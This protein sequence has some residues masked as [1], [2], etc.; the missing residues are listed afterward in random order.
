MHAPNT[1]IHQCYGLSGTTGNSRASGR[2]P[3]RCSHRSTAGSPRALTRLTCKRPSRYSTNWGDNTG[4]QNTLLQQIA[5]F[6][7]YG[8]LTAFEKN[9]HAICP[10]I[11]APQDDISLRQTRIGWPCSL[12]SIAQSPSTISPRTR[13]FAADNPAV[14]TQ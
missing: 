13:R 5:Q 4:E 7:Y 10:C 3:A 9:G 14:L 12:R 2:R 8:L 6:W 1:L 11:E